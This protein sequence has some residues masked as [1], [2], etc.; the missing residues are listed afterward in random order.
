[1]EREKFESLHGHS[2]CFILLC[3]QMQMLC[4][5]SA[6]VLIKCHLTNVPHRFSLLLRKKNLPH[7]IFKSEAT[8][9][10]KNPMT[11]NTFMSPKRLKIRTKNES[12]A[13]G[14]FLSQFYLSENSISVTVFK[15]SG[16]VPFESEQEALSWSN[17][18]CLILGYGSLF[19]RL[20][21]AKERCEIKKRYISCHVRYF[22]QLS[23]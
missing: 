15:W 9:K 8:L 20:L 1:M 23:K 14:F 4:K 2:K 3:I 13:A 16:L 11:T 12:R 17:Y 22:L 19:R 21:E 7:D 5:Y 6:C 10:W 18:S